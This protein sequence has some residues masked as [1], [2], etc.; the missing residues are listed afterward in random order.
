MTDSFITIVI[1]TLNER[2]YIIETITEISAGLAGRDHEI[3]VADGGSS[4]GTQDLVTEYAK[5]HPTVRLLHN[6]CRLQ[7]AAVNIA[8]QM[9]DARSTVLVRVDAHC[10][11]P[12]NFIDL[13]VDALRANNAQSVVVPMFTMGSE[14]VYQEAVA[15]AQNS[16]LG[17]GGSS[18]RSGGTPSTWVDHGHHAAFDLEFF[19]LIGGY[20]ES[21][22]TNEDA[23]YDV[24]VAKAG[25]RIWM[26]R[27]AEITYYPRRSPSSLAKQYFKYGVGRAS[28][29]LKHK[30]CPRPRQMAPVVI[31]LVLLAS[32]LSLPICLYSVL[33]ILGYLGLCLHYGMKQSPSFGPGALRICSAFVIMHNAWAAG[34]ISRVFSSLFRR[35][36]RNDH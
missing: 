1:P 36:S 26:C 32:F 20:D 33:P 34:F 15:L 24:R 17:N 23:E 14:T 21:F 18:H 35:R 10:S 3:I 19:K 8:T 25:G 7:S 11:Y 16:K 13:V 29:V 27:E 22:A 6:P 5:A 4:D 31:F 12:E 2:D 28:T 9:A 30:I